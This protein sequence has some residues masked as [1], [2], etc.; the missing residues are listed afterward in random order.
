MREFLYKFLV[1]YKWYFKAKVETGLPI[2][3]IASHRI[4]F[5]ESGAG[6]EES[7]E[8]LRVINSVL[9]LGSIL[10]YEYL[11]LYNDLVV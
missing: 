6:S 2:K 1:A 4:Y 5:V 9:K 7:S 3:S 8:I 10:L 11:F